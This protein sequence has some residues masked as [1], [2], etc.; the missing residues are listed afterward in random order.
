M[1]GERYVISKL[2]FWIVTD[3]NSLILAEL[4]F[5]ISRMNG[6]FSVTLKKIG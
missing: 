5:V 3:V 4:E 1:G 6:F 2:V